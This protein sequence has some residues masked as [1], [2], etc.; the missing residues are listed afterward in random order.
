MILTVK[1][2]YLLL[3]KVVCSTNLS[4]NSISKDTSG[5]CEINQCLIYNPD[6]E[7]VPSDEDN[8]MSSVSEGVP[9]ALLAQQMGVVQMLVL[10]SKDA[11]P[12][13]LLA[14][15]FRNSFPRTF[16]SPGPDIQ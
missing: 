6:G 4:N 8:T 1:Q 16:I 7:A 3:A 2:D 14:Q 15:K 9:K 11:K 10:K 13:V 5:W 12:G